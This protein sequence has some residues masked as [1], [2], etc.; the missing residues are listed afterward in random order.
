MKYF[1]LIAAI[2]FSCS[3]KSGNVLAEEGPKKSNDTLL[4]EEPAFTEPLTEKV[5]DPSH[6]HDS[7][8]V[9]ISLLSKDFIYDLK[10]ATDD[11]FLDHA[12][13]PCSDC[14]LRL[15][16]ARKLIEANKYFIKQGYRIKLFD[17]YRPLSVQKKMWEI[18]PDPRYVANPYS[19]NGSYH[20]R[21]GAVDITLVDMQNNELDMGTPF[22]H[23]GIDSH[24][25]NKNLPGTVIANRIFLREG[26]EMAGFNGI[27]TEWWHFSTGNYPVT[28]EQLCPE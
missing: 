7:S 15:G 28:N 13:Y 22:D 24:F 2:L 21:G 27:R 10:Y 19:S 9:D 4:V 1:F 16:V 18:M 20:N 8:L 5:V 26:M 14:F 17:C 25:D 6:Y 23:F 3:K 12:V 11:N